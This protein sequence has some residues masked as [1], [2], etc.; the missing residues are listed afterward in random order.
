MIP[1]DNMTL[2]ARYETQLEGTQTWLVEWI[3]ELLILQ[4]I[5]NYAY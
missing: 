1:K 5:W 2:E 3:H 4:S